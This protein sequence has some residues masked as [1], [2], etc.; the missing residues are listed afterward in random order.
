M[1][2]ESFF[3]LLKPVSVSLRGWA[4]KHVYLFLIPKEHLNAYISM[5]QDII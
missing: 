4:I 5:R 2:P 1:L 3:F